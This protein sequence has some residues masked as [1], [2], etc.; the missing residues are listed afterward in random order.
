MLK[1][2]LV[3]SL[4]CGLSLTT[5]DTSARQANKP[6]QKLIIPT[7]LQQ[8]WGGLTAQDEAETQ[9]LVLIAAEHDRSLAQTL[10][11]SL[12]AN[13]KITTS[14]LDQ[15]L[16]EL[17]ALSLDMKRLDWIR[18]RIDDLAPTKSWLQVNQTLGSTRTQEAIK[19]LALRSAS[20]WGCE[21][22]QL[23][24]S[25]WPELLQ[26]EYAI[27]NL[28]LS[29]TSCGG[30]SLDTSSRWTPVQNQRLQAMVGNREKSIAFADL[31][32]LFADACTGKD[33]VDRFQICKWLRE[34][35]EIKKKALPNFKL[36]GY[37]RVPLKPQDDL[38]SRDA[39]EV[40]LSELAPPTGE[41][42]KRLISMLARN[43]A[44]R[45]LDAYW[46]NKDGTQLILE[47]WL[48]TPDTKNKPAYL[49]T[50]EMAARYLVR[51]SETSIVWLPLPTSLGQYD[52]GSLMSITDLDD[53]GNIEIWTRAEWG[54]CDG[55]GLT[56]GKDCAIPHYF[57]F[58]QYG[59]RFL[60]FVRGATPQ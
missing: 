36:Q 16:D 56:P 33:Y 19:R 57:R 10:R 34:P 59:E 44:P 4:V 13:S 32:R 45:V 30:L 37:I 29:Q 38:K 60:P 58:E 7:R 20:K 15:N 12:D 48:S 53:D 1:W 52:D 39:L 51:V 14:Q 26:V 6:P 22:I 41:R 25:G 46:K 49:G 2:L 24:V 18:A 11:M 31:A 28:E 43:P 9:R 17:L 21:P 54:E 27:A 50:D 47:L 42:V 35:T 8:K 5:P 23:Q 55:E 40:W 3:G